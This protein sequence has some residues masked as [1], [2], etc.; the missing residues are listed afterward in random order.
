VRLR[1]VRHPPLHLIPPTS[2]SLQSPEKSESYFS[3]CCKRLRRGIPRRPHDVG[4]LQCRL[5]VLAHAHGVWPGLPSSRQAGS[6]SPLMRLLPP[7]QR[8]EQS[9]AQM[10][11]WSSYMLQV[12][13][14]RSERGM[15]V[16]SVS[17]GYGVL[18]RAVRLRVGKYADGEK[19]GANAGWGP[20]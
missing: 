13:V 19:V 18:R 14:P 4:A 20:S 3:T 17:S 16:R 10:R 9:Y 8:R 7:R 15:S 11:H 12:S 5:R 1:A 2:S 6:R